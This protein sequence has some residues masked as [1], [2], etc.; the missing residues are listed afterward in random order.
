MMITCGVEWN[1]ILQQ[2][3]A[4]SNKIYNYLS[5]SGKHSIRQIFYGKFTILGVLN[6]RLHFLK[7]QEK[8][9]LFF[10]VN[11]IS[12]DLIKSSV[13]LAPWGQ[14]RDI[15]GKVCNS[16]ILPELLFMKET[17]LQWNRFSLGRLALISIPSI[18]RGI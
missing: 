6:E 4:F 9:I 2:K 12:G 11:V 1:D 3:Q 18:V 13:S 14:L 10:E 5:F 8:L 17:S 7:K 16:P 15:S